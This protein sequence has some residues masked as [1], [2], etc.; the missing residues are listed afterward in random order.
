[1]GT[2]RSATEQSQVLRR[3]SAGESFRGALSRFQPEQIVR[4]LATFP[5]SVRI[6]ARQGEEVIHVDVGNG[7][8]MGADRA[9]CAERVPGVEAFKRFLAMR[10]GDVEVV[11][12]RFSQLANLFLPMDQA[13]DA[14]P[15]VAFARVNPSRPPTVPQVIMP[16]EVI[17]DEPENP[18]VGDASDRGG[19][20]ARKPERPRRVQAALPHDE[21]S[22]APTVLESWGPAKRRWTAITLAACC[23]GAFVIGSTTGV[24]V[25]RGADTGADTGVDTGAPVDSPPLLASLSPADQSTTRV[26]DAADLMREARNLMRRGETGHALNAAHEAV[27]LRSDV[28]NYQV[29]LGDAFLMNGRIA[30]AE[31]AWRRALEL[32]P[33]HQ[34]AR[35]RLSRHVE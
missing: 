1:M 19:A 35:R 24:A 22:I 28:P 32:E 6:S 34:V 14:K 3:I 29:V 26:P 4:E 15:R 31:H 12:T 20:A 16:R 8:I 23:L 21:A 10:E 13:F 25:D 30:E 2:S 11:P 7:V 18:Q 9:E 5:G 27:A 33:S 17:H